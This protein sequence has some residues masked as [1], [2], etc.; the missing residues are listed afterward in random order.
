MRWPRSTI[1]IAP[2]RPSN[3]EL[4]GQ[5]LSRTTVDSPFREPPTALTLNW[6][7]RHLLYPRLSWCIGVCRG[8]YTVVV[9]YRRVSCRIGVRRAR[10]SAAGPTG[11]DLLSSTG[12]ATYGILRKHGRG[13]LQ[14]NC[15]GGRPSMVLFIEARR[16]ASGNQIGANRAPNGSTPIERCLASVDPFDEWVRPAA[17]PFR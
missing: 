5:Q 11:V 14:K 17:E 1:R 16:L 7:L 8:V 4:I 12:C 13:T 6:H 15:R 2:N 10:W 3:S 9:M